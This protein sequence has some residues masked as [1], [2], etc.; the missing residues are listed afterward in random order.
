MT[1]ADLAKQIAEAIFDTIETK[2]RIVKDDLVEATERVLAKACG[3]AAK[4]ILDAGQYRNFPG[5]LFM[6]GR[7]K[8]T[9]CGSAPQAG[10]W[11]EP[12]DASKW[13][14]AGDTIKA[15]DLVVLDDLP[16]KQTAEQRKRVID[17]YK[18]NL[19]APMTVSRVYPKITNDGV[20]LHSCSH[21]RAPVKD[22][23]AAMR[24][25]DTIEIT[26]AEFRDLDGDTT[27]L[28]FTSP[29]FAP[30]TDLVRSVYIVRKVR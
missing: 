8:V 2:R 16:T 30:Q 10:A 19:A 14:V 21:P 17:W 26:F 20:E 27:R 5:F 9:N 24:V 1:N 22:C 29:Q 4:D 28:I 13:V 18:M 7:P 11:S 6:N 12:E 15:G 3:V 23:L 25:G